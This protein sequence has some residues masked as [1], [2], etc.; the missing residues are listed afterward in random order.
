ALGCNV[1]Q[2]RALSSGG[3]ATATVSPIVRPASPPPNVPYATPPA[4]ASTS[5]VTVKPDDPRIRDA[6]PVSLPT[7]DGPATLI[8]SAAYP[9]VLPIGA[10]VLVMHE[11]TGL[12]EHIKDVIRRVATAG[13]AR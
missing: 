1:E 11:N 9:A 3:V 2:P 10:G 7:T 5:P 6:G 4:T 13:Y 12:T 8:G